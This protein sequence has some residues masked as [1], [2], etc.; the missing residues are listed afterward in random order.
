V[1]WDQRFDDAIVLPGRKPLVTPRDAALYIAKL[2]KATERSGGLPSGGDRPSLRA[3]SYL[4]EDL[5]HV[6]VRV[7]EENRTMAEGV[8]GQ[9]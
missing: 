2:P 9:R 5:K 3:T 8:I 1:S 6:A 4:R 7:A